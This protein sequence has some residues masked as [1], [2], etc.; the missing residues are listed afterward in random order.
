M[1]EIR[2]QLAVIR[3]EEESYKDACL[4]TKNMNTEEDVDISWHNYF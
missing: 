2:Q 3:S 4:R 1:I